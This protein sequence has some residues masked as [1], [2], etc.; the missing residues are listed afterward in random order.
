MKNFNNSE[1]RFLC[2]HL[3]HTPEVHD[4]WYRMRRSAVEFAKV[5]KILADDFNEEEARHQEEEDQGSDVE[6]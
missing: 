1:Y 6:E 3:G 4:R 5:G 2:D